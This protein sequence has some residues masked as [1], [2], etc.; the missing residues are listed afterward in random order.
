MAFFEN[1][2]KKIGSV[3]ETAADKANE[4]AE[5]TKLNNSISSEQK[6]I[7]GLFIE[8]GKLIFEREK[9]D[10]DSPIAEQCRK[11]LISQNSIAEFQSKIEQI[12]GSNGQPAGNAAQADANYCSNCGAVI[13]ENGKFCQS[14][15][16]PFNG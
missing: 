1:L 5:I 15:G 7:D 14:C 16:T 11:I 8:I 12:K 9:E 10:Q 2:G 4:F 13:P 6:Q 3:A